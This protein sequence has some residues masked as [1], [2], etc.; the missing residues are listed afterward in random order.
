[1]NSSTPA[2]GVALDNLVSRAVDLMSSQ[3]AM[4]D[5]FL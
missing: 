1:M 2:N 3:Q 5:E 4:P